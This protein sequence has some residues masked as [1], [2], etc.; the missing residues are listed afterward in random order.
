MWV[1][2]GCSQY[3]LRLQSS[4]GLIGAGGFSAERPRWSE[5]PNNVVAASLRL[6]SERGGRPRAFRPSLR[7]HTGQFCPISFVRSKSPSSAHTQGGQTPPFERRIG[8]GFGGEFPNHYTVYL[9]GFGLGS[10]KCLYKPRQNW[11]LLSY[12]AYKLPSWLAQP[13]G[14]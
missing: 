5:Y 11:G 8:K 6:K 3:L 7:R 14:C 9:R 4:E 12:P 1:L 10:L 2:S 13:H